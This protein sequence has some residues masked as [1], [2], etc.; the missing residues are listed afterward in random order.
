[1]V[2]IFAGCSQERSASPS[3]KEKQKPEE[4]PRHKPHGKRGPS[5]W[6]ADL[7]GGSPSKVSREPLAVWGRNQ[8]ASV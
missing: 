7:K 5:T 1:M 8:V 4:E 2:S 3:G 6:A